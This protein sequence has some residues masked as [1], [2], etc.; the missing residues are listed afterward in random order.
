MKTAERSDLSGGFLY[1]SAEPALAIAFER[2]PM[3]EVSVS[4]E[5]I[6]YRMTLASRASSLLFILIP[7]TMVEKKRDSGVQVH[8]PRPLCFTSFSIS[9][10]RGESPAYPSPACGG[11]SRLSL[12]IEVKEISIKFYVPQFIVFVNCTFS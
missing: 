10:P 8:S 1:Y 5:S 9:P 2:Q 3:R 12:S 7:Q 4:R 6:I 11:G